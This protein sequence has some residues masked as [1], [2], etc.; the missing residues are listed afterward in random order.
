MNEANAKL[1]P[2]SDKFGYVSDGT[3]RSI[4]IVE[5]DKNSRIFYIFA[6]PYIAILARTKACLLMCCR[7]SEALHVICCLP[8]F[9]AR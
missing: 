1:P 7:S 8:G 6:H 4:R 3:K 9:F 5:D 2:P